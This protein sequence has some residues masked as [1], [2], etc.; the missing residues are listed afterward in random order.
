MSRSSTGGFNFC[1]PLVRYRTGDSAALGMAAD[2]PILRDFSG[3]RPIRFRTASGR[4]VNNIDISHALSELSAAQFAV[5][6]DAVGAITLALSAEAVAEAARA[7]S[8]LARLM[9][10][11]PI[12]ITTIMSEDK[13]LQYTSDLNGSMTG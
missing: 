5:H 10:D 12:A 13:A 7:E 4:W 9:G 6:Q 11:V 1:L 8:A 3:R 2:D